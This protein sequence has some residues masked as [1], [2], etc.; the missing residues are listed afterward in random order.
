M[1]PQERAEKIVSDWNIDDGVALLERTIAAQID[2]AERDVIE[3]K[4]LELLRQHRE[5]FD[6]LMSTQPGKE[7]KTDEPS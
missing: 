1:T 2:E 5:F 7:E 6:W 4:R 3:E